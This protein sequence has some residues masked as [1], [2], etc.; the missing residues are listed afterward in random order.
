MHENRQGKVSETGLT[1]PHCTAAEQW[2]WWQK[3]GNVENIN[4]PHGSCKEPTLN[5]TPSPCTT[6]PLHGTKGS[7][8]SYFRH[9]QLLPSK[10]PET[11]CRTSLTRSDGAAIIAVV[12]NQVPEYVDANP[13]IMQQ[14]GSLGGYSAEFRKTVWDAEKL[15]P[16]SWAGWDTSACICSFGTRIKWKTNLGLR[17]HACNKRLAVRMGFLSHRFWRSFQKDL[18]L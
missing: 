3:V 6:P 13:T 7:S 16:I 12:Q 9:S 2:W 14:D 10:C 5:S 1:V 11:F 4:T 15:A 18:Q 8:C 17:Q